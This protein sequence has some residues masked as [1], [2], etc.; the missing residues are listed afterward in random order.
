MSRL[1]A[2]APAVASSEKVDSLL[3]TWQNPESR[4]YFLMGVLGK[5]SANDFTFTYY[6][7]VEEQ[8]GFRAIPGFKD[9]NREY[10]SSTL[11]P[12]FSSRI[13]SH[14]RGDRAGW[15]KS[16]DLTDE[17]ESL[18]ILGRSLGLKATDTFEL[19]PEPTV[20][21][22]HRTVTADAPLHGLRY[23]SPGKELVQRGGVGVGEVLQLVPEP[24]N[25]VDPRAV[26][27]ITAHGVQLG[28]VPAPLLDYLE[29]GG[30]PRKAGKAT[31][32][33]VNTEHLG[34]HQQLLLKYCWAE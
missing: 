24:D 33:H 9:L 21:L 25:P 1:V 30:Y 2:N 22:A 34:L 26:A 20:D 5:N 17:S 10:T 29:R 11:F 15:L 32:T 12:L 28:Y 13:M 7:G 8:E 19:Y 18:E 14:S 23:M 6:R 27:V 31:L 16:F 3:V 4:S